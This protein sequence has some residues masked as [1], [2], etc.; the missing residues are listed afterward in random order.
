MIGQICKDYIA[1]L[2]ALYNK[3][4]TASQDIYSVSKCAVFNGK[5]Y[6][7]IVCLYVILSL[8]SSMSMADC[9][10][11]LVLLNWV[12]SIRMN[13]IHC[14]TKCYRIYRSTV[15]EKEHY[16]IFSIYFSILRIILH[17]EWKMLCAFAEVIKN[18]IHAKVRN[19]Q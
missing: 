12:Q 13:L 10:Y 4:R 5:C 17:P 6:S 19:Q 16:W 7:F 2:H 18:D 9:V 3:Q 15:N 11:C 8:L 14:E 1:S